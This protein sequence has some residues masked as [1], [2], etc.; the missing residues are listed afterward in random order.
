MTT[1]PEVEARF[2][3]FVEHHVIHGESLPVDALCADRPD[4][5][6]ALFALVREYLEVTRLFEHAPPPAEAS[7]SGPQVL[8]VF[9]GFQTVERLGAGG[10]GE[11]YKVR[12]LTLDRIVAAKIVRQGSAAASR[13]GDFVREAKSLALFSDRR[14]VQIHELRWDATPAV[15]IM[16]YVDGFELGRIGPSLEP[17]QRARLLREV[18]DGV[19]HAHALGIQHRD[20]KPSNIMVTAALQPKILDFGLASGD[21]ARGHFVGT[22][23]YLAPEQLDAARPIDARVDVYALGVILYQLLCGALPYDGATTGDLLDAIRR[24]EPRLPIE[25]APDAPEPL[26]AIA[27]KAMERDPAAR[28]ASAREMALDL[29]RFINGRPVLARPTVY[30]SALGARV[31]P[32]V[33]Q[34]AEWQRLA[35]IYPHEA[36]DLRGAYR[37][38]EKRE[39]DWI[40]ESRTLSYSQIALYLGAFLM[41]GGSLFYFAAE[42]FFDAVKGLTGPVIVLGAPFVALNVA[43]ARL[44]RRERQAVAVA[45]Y[46]AGLSLLPLFLLILFKQVHL[47]VVP[48]DTPDQLFPDVRLFEGPIV[49]G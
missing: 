12:D 16:E 44:Y 3:R 13:Y 4:L 23:A 26:Q 34:I 8:P 19:H 1:N 6:P 29:E 36:Q 38:I 27:L 45:F 48:S 14:I 32:H 10:M 22:Q 31:R 39:D 47:W 30:A 2:E 42:R 40:I 49:V 33:D 7:A 37:R 35:L 9:E 20:L 41:L 11:V 46:L 25:I 18:C 28:Y 17:A 21:P 15:I 43:A 24:G 5:A